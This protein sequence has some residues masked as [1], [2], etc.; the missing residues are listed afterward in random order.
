VPVH[1]FATLT[2]EQSLDVDGV[3]EKSDSIYKAESLLIG[4]LMI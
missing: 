4:A 1:I 2:A 3:K